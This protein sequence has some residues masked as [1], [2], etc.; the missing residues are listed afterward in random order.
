MRGRGKRGPLDQQ[1][2]AVSAAGL[3][4]CVARH[5]AALAEVNRKQAE[6]ITSLRAK[7]KDS[8]DRLEAIKRAVGPKAAKV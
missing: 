2:D 4:R 6:D 5:G 1:N 3:E 8:A 7:V